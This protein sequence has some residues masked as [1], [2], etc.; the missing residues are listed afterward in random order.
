MKNDIHAR[1]HQSDSG[2]GVRA[3]KPLML[4][5]VKAK[6]K[7]RKRIMILSDAGGQTLH[8]LNI[9]NTTAAQGH[10]IARDD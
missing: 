1:S 7:M 3:K 8:G 10:I 2:N 6:P 9:A 5:K 4:N